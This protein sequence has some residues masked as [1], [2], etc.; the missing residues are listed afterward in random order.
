MPLGNTAI[1]YGTITK[2]FHWTIALMVLTMF[3]LGWIARTLAGWIEAPDIATTD[4]TITLTK[5]LFSIH[6]TMGVTIF[7]L[8]VLRI[9]WAISQPKPGLLN[10]DKWLESRLAETVH[11]LLY[12]SLVAVPLSG[13]VYHAATTGYAPIWWPFGQGLP[14]VSEDA[15]L[16]EISSAL[17]FILQWVLAVAIALHVAGAMKHHV[18]DRDATLRRM[19]PGRQTALPTANQPGH[20][21]PILAALAIWGAAIGLGASLGWLSPR[22]GAQ[23]E[24]LAEVSS[25]WRV[26]DGALNIAILQNNSEVTGSFADWTADITYGETPDAEG[27]HGAVTVTVSIPSL[28][29]GS[30]TD[31]AMGPAYFAAQEWPTATLQA[32]LI[33][34]GDGLLANGTLRIRD[35]SVP[36]S[37]PVDL[38]IDGDTAD[39]AGSLTVDR[40]DFGIGTGTQDESS[41]AF[42]V[43]IDWTL[44]ATRAPEASVE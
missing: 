39:A 5:L 2:V 15:A 35:Q 37:M 18:I 12:G 25:D 28:S 38:T 7:A 33:D 13:W 21:L 27:K 22:E 44:T 40:L 26:E 23:A 36:V 19:L 32:D 34:A 43:R 41:L 1:S 4:A 10:G 31:Q 17:H 20:A 8:A 9:L 42:A 16:A 30:V 11:W 24:A 6:K 29:L 3:A 14:F